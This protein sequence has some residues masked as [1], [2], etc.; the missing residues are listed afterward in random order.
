MRMQWTALALCPWLLP[1]GGCAVTPA[2]AYPR[3]ELDLPAAV[4]ARYALPGPVQEVV[5]APL[6]A[7]HRTLRWERGLLRCG[8]ETVD[9]RVVRPLGAG[10]HPFVVLVP[11]LAGGEPVLALVAEQL[12]EGGRAV[13]FARRAGAAMRPPQRSPEMELL[14]RRSVVHNRI[15]LA[16]ARRQ[17]WV[18][19]DRLGLVGISMGGLLGA[20]VV[21]VEPDLRAAVLCLAGADTP[22]LM[23]QSR[24]NRV[25]EWRRWRRAEDGLDGGELEREL[26]HWLVSDPM[27]LAPYV[28]TEK[29][30]LL[31]TAF[32][33]VVPARNQA[34]LWEALGRP[35]RCTF[36][37]GHYTAAL[38]LPFLL[39]R[40]D[41]F[42]TERFAGESTVPPVP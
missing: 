23:L 29:V 32:D 3:P 15:V 40:I 42:L 24:E 27:R 11:I 9:F 18:D 12:A 5:A 38:A 13:A 10:P 19:P 2:S 20:A 41:A 37:L 36:A 26:R 16:W 30:L 1:L 17:T 33:E 34:L 6:A 28:A 21:A 22:D 39:A 31:D 25:I 4:A 14:F 7:E 35:R 8:D